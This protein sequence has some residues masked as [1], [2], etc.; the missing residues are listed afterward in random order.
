M[1]EAVIIGPW[2]HNENGNFPQV[3]LNYVLDRYEDITGQPGENI[4]TDPN[5]FVHRIRCTADVLVQ[6]E[7][8]ATYTV[9]TSE[10]V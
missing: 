6:I 8:D 9:L 5:V 3:V 7:A 2:V 10:E 4:P 1:I